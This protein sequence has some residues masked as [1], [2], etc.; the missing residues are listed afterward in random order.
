MKRILTASLAWLFLMAMPLAMQAGPVQL[1]A[2]SSAIVTSVE[3]QPGSFAAFPISLLT[4][5][6]APSGEG[7]NVTLRATATPH[8]ITYT[9]TASTSAYTGLGYNLYIGTTPGGEGSTP[10]NPSLTAVGCSGASCTYSFTNVTPLQTYY[11]TLAACVP[12]AGTTTC[13]ASTAEVASTIPLGP[14]DINAPTGFSGSA[15]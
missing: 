6:S 7:G 10:V 1:T 5:Q 14:S 13:S 15:R 12:N 2:H 9:W 3:V 4:A 8:G 11:G